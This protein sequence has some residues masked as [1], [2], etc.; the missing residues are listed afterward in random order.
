MPGF[1][2]ENIAGAHENRVKPAVEDEAVKIDP[3]IYE[4]LKAFRVNRKGSK[5]GGLHMLK[6]KVK[7][8]KRS[9]MGESFM[10]KR[11]IDEAL[12]DKKTNDVYSR[13]NLSQ[14]QKR[15]F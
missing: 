3:K 8:R 5:K 15:R 4:L 9:E 6:V 7:K 14:D 12:A 11:T 2:A 10:L 13:F 1:F